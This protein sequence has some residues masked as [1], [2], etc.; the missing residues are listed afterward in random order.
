MQDKEPEAIA[1]NDAMT[2]GVEFQGKHEG[3]G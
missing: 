2:E 3:A 1:Y